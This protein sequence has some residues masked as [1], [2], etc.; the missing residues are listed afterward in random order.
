MKWLKWQKKTAMANV[1][2]M[3]NMAKMAN[4][5]NIAY[6]SGRWEVHRLKLAGKCI[7]GPP[8]S[9]AYVSSW[10]ARPSGKLKTLMEV[11]PSQGN[12]R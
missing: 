9:V 3:V 2:K 4:M 8:D 5:A 7:A 1:A 12:T 11:R 6:L 10:P